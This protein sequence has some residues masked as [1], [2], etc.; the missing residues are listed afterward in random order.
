MTVPT[1]LVIRLP[2]CS[3]LLPGMMISIVLKTLYYNNFKF[4]VTFLIM[5]VERV[6]PLSEV[7]IS[8]EREFIKL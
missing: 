3:L 5:F 2:F 1:N 6:D 4:F 8:I 7:H